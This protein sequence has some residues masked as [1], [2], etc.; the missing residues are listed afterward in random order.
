MKA[1]PGSEVHRIFGE[2]R[3]TWCLEWPDAPRDLLGHLDVSRR[4]LCHGSPVVQD[5]GGRSVTPDSEMGRLKLTSP[6]MSLYGCTVRL[7]VDT[8]VV[9]AGFRSVSGASNRLLRY[10][11]DGSAK[12]LCSTALFLEYEAVL[13]R[14]NIRQATRHTLEDVQVVMNAIAA[15]AEPVDVPL[16]TRPTLHD[17][18]DEI[19]LDRAQRC[20]RLHRHA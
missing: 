13:S 6:G 5:L 18:D 14:R 15:I 3:S 11:N 2:Q 19:V 16:I 12:L 10:A 8:N 20:G 1:T 9:V 17:A 4:S 7:V